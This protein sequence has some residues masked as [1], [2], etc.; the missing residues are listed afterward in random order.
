MNHLSD[1]QFEDLVHG[2]QAEPDHLRD[3]AACRAQLT[4][5]QALA[6]RLQGAFV[7]ME[8]GADLRSRILAATQA[9]STGETGSLRIRVHRHLWSVLAAAAVV[10]LGA[11]PV[12]LFRH[13]ASQVQASQSELSG[14]HHHTLDHPEKLFHDED[15]QRVAERLEDQTGHRPALIEPC[16]SWVICGSRTCTFKGRIVPTYMVESTSGRVSVVILAETPKDLGMKH[17]PVRGTWTATCKCC[18]MAAVRLDAD[19]YYA[20]GDVP[21]AVLA[22]VLDRI[23]P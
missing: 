9:E 15:P 1:E 19:T 14:I 7:D 3:C 11:V 12:T 10:L 20:L 8:A 18:R 17:D 13:T 23:V 4:E 2:H 5:R 21:H 16:E 22:E 6:A